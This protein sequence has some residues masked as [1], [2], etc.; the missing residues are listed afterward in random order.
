MCLVKTHK[1]KSQ[2]LQCGSQSTDMYLHFGRTLPPGQSDDLRAVL[3]TRR[4]WSQPQSV[5]QLDLVEQPLLSLPAVAAV[6]MQSPLA[7]CR[8]PPSCQQLCQ[9]QR[10]VWR[11]EIQAFGRAGR[12]SL[13]QFSQ[14][15]KGLAL[16]LWPTPLPL[17]VVRQKLHQPEVF[18]LWVGLCGSR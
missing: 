3:R 13:Q 4:V 16:S 9:G 2:P 18:W 12:E 8:C 10:E 1:T 7:C 11:S 15:L 5:Q 14:Q 17:S 6:V